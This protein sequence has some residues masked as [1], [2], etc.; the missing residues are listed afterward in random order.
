VKAITVSS[1]A[2]SQRSERS[3]AGGMV[4]EEVI[5]LGRE[6]S[7]KVES[8]ALGGETTPSTRYRRCRSVIL[9]AGS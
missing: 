4:V 1:D 7:A 3:D 9:V 2:E 6:E 5:G 8:D